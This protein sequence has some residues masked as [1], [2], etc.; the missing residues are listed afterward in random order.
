MCRG[1]GVKNQVLLQ[2]SFYICSEPFNQTAHWLDGPDPLTR[3]NIRE[4]RP[5]LC[6]MFGTS[7]VGCGLLGVSVGLKT[8]DRWVNR[9][10]DFS[11]LVIFNNF[12]LYC[13]ISCLP[14]LQRTFY[15]QRTYAPLQRM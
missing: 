6:K 15:H 13:V 2:S 10:E 3:Q 9:D 8:P 5:L 7:K 1:V 14:P 12:S 4:F 11:N